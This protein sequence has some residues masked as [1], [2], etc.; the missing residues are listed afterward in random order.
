M[1]ELAEYKERLFERP[2]GQFKNGQFDDKCCLLC[3]RQGGDVF[4]YSSN[5]CRGNEAYLLCEACHYAGVSLPVVVADYFE[6]YRCR[7]S[8]RDAHQKYPE[9]VAAHKSL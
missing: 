3:G 7:Y 8:Y 5:E 9:D 6:T 2:H 4:V 1:K